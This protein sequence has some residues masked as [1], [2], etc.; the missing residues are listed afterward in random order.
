[1][2]LEW[3][4]LAEQQLDEILAFYTRRN[5]NS[6]YSKKLKKDIWKVLRHIRKNEH[7]GEALPRLGNTRRISVGN[8][9]L[10]YEYTDNIVQ[11]ISI[12]H[13]SRDEE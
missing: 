7:F 13:S 1:M 5:G 12:R 4:H 11:I 3:T 2:K 9:V 8:F 10:I 6:R